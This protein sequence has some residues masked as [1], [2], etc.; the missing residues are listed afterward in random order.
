MKSSFFVISALVAGAS[1]HE[2]PE[3]A[4]YHG[5]TEPY[6]DD[7]TQYQDAAI[8]DF[9]EVNKKKV[10][11]L[12][13]VSQA[14]VAPVAKPISGATKPQSG[15]KQNDAKKTP[16]KPEKD[17][18]PEPPH[19]LAEAELTPENLGKRDIETEM[20]NNISDNEYL[21]VNK[22]GRFAFLIKNIQGPEDL[23]FIQP[24]EISFLQTDV[25]KSKKGW[26]GRKIT[27]AD[28]DGIEDNVALD[29]YELDEFYD[30]LVFGVAEDVHNTRHGNLPGHNQLWFTESL[31]E[32]ANHRQDIVQKPWVTE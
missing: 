15:S 29:H 11:Q 5:T 13:Q 21:Q 32:P 10:E 4:A 24:E 20:S 16:A 17:S 27:D 31:N 1:S 25:S 12:S 14:P 9:I 28:G 8:K 26:H 22:Q 6:F 23:S 3:A 7:E 18:L 19:A 2:G 30:P